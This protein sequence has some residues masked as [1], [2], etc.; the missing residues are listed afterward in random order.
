M[1]PMVILGILGS[2]GAAISWFAFNEN[3]K[4][5]AIIA[6]QPLIKEAH[7]TVILMAGLM[8]R[9]R[10]VKSLDQP[11]G[12]L[13]DEAA[14][15]WERIMVTL[16]SPYWQNPNLADHWKRVRGQSVTAADQ[17]MNEIL[18]LLAHT[19]RPE[20]AQGWQNVL[21]GLL[22]QYVG[23]A[24]PE[25]S[26][27]LP[28]GF[29]PARE[30]AEKLKILASETERLNMQVLQESESRNIASTSAIDLCLNEMRN[31]EQAESELHQTMGGTSS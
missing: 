15:H 10:L 16:D 31:L 27:P 19:V 14:R 30:I 3:R 24:R 17:A 25:Q 13:L 22:E 1:V 26:G 9:N 20:N 2:A 7:E 29:F 8:H 6:Q 11:V 18:V 21:E 12:Q 28:S 5:Q 23:V 4:E